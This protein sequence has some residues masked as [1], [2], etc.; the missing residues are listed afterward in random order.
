MIKP[1]NRW[2][3]MAVIAVTL[4]TIGLYGINRANPWRPAPIRTP[5]QEYAYYRIVDE[6]TGKTLMTISS[7]PVIIGDEL[8]TEGNKWYVVVKVEGNLAYAR[9]VKTIKLDE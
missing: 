3:L 1:F 2:I 8:L 9:Y 7:G 6:K 4:V 5:R